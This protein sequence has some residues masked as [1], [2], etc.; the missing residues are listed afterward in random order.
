MTQSRPAQ[1]LATVYTRSEIMA[2]VAEMGKQIS[3]F[4]GDEPLVAVCA[5]KGAVFFF[6]DLVRAMNRPSL[7]IDF[8]RLASYGRN[9]ESSGN[10]VLGK[11]VET[12]I[13]GK[14]VL[15]VEDI[16]DSGQTMR[17]L[18]EQ[19][20]ARQPLS[21]RIAALVEKSGRRQTDIKADFAG[22]YRKDG[23]LVGYGMD[24]AEQYRALPDI[25]E[26]AV[27]E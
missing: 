14:H 9:S 20:A 17:F 15:V 12:D 26:L 8:V 2:K 25:C 10:V 24:Y 6:S 22:F 3:D 27:D 18:L 1:K 13:R 21:V 5:L 19:F 16:V 4:Y 11:D 23:F 7:E